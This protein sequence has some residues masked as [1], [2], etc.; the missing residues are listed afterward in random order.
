MNL[1]E[2][3]LMWG[4]ILRFER[5]SAGGL[6]SAVRFANAVAAWLLE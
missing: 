2:V 5:R 1:R 4:F 3:R 6:G